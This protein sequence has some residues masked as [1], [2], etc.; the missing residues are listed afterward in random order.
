VL[1][2][3]SMVHRHAVAAGRGAH[4]EGGRLVG[5]V[6]ARHRGSRVHWDGKRDAWLVA[7]GGGGAW[8]CRRG[9]V[10]PVVAAAAAA[11]PAGLG[12][13]L[14]RRPKPTAW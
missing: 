5:G 1:R 7:S 13:M 14:L 4:K 12:A 11:G 10:T 3:A 8:A 2:R 9:A 6:P